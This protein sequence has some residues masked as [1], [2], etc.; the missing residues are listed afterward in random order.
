[1]YSPMGLTPDNDLRFCGGARRDPRVLRRIYRA[2]AEAVG[3]GRSKRGL[4]SA[5]RER[6]PDC[7]AML[8][9]A[10]RFVNHARV[11]LRLCPAQGRGGRTMRRRSTNWTSASSL[12]TPVTS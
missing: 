12:V 9:C 10:T 2:R 8:G 7:A 6:T 5:L 1:R 3:P 4:G 11:P